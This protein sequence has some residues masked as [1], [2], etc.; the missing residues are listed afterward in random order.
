MTDYAPC[1]ILLV[2]DNPT[3]LEVTVEG[4]KEEGYDVEVAS[5]GEE[6]ISKAGGKSYD[7]VITDLAMPGMN[8]MDVLAHLTERHPEITVV[9]LTGYGT[10]ETAV[11]AMKR[12]AFEYL[13]K[14]AKLDEILLVIRRAQEIRTLKAENTFLRSQLQDQYRFEKIV[15]QSL[16]MQQLYRMMQRVAKTDSTVLVTGESGTGKELIANAIHYGSERRDNPFVPINCGAIPE[17][18]LESELFG[19]EKGAFTGAFK[20]R[21]GR[22]ELANKGTAFLDEIGEMSPKLQVK[23][24]RF[25]QERKFERIGDSRSIEV[26]VRIIAATNKDMEKAVADGEFRE[27]LY[28]RLNV[29][30]IHV[31]PLRRREGD[32]PVL[33][34]HFMRQHCEKM[35][36]TPKRVSKEA[37]KCLESYEW[38]G[39]VRELENLMERLLILTE[40]DEIGVHDLPQRMRHKADSSFSLQLELGE[41]GIDLKKT[42]DELESRL[43]LEALKRTGG[44][45]NQAAKALGLK[46]TTLIEKMKK[47]RIEYPSSLN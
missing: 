16:P 8:G 2:D 34:Q 10:I 47:K 4:L 43:I 41:E 5:S 7:I 32:I 30:P 14:P 22:F 31:P 29:V 26:D 25:L 13:T 12:G 19:Y 11:E 28:F 38:P 23:L 46:R 35:S 44:V 6:G 39:N 15:G 42:L 37:L 45:K 36:I 40:S 20:T 27:D 21:K 33:V 1:S 9:V 3:T 18:L 17:E 24:L